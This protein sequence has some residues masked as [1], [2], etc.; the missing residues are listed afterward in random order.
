M[1]RET[2]L[3][4]ELRSPAHAAKGRTRTRDPQL[5]KAQAPLTEPPTYSSCLAGDCTQ[6][7]PVRLPALSGSGFGA[8]PTPLGH[9]DS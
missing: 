5:G 2:G 9:R 1:E 8:P 6:L 3:A 7:H 4:G